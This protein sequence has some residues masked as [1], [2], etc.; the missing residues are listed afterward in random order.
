MALYDRQELVHHKRAKEKRYLNICTDYTQTQTPH[1]LQLLLLCV[2]AGVS[3]MF[4]QV[5]I[6]LVLNGESL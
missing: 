3:N 4:L 2:A 1:H 5:L 6:C